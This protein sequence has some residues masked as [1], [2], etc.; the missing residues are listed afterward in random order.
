MGVLTADVPMSTYGS[1]T[2]LSFS[3]NAALT[4]YKGALLFADEGGGVCLRFRIGFGG[5]FF[6][7]HIEPAAR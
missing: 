6:E 2:K 5:E 7:G 1:P 3:A 4:F